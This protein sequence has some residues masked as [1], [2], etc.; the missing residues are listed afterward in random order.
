MNHEPTLSAIRAE[1]AQ[2]HAQLDVDDESITVGAGHPMAQGLIPVEDV[3]ALAETAQL[4][5][6]LY[7][8]EATHREVAANADDA[9][10]EIARLN[11]RIEELERRCAEHAALRHQVISPVGMELVKLAHRWKRSRRGH[12]L[13]GGLYD[14]RER[15][16]HLDLVAELE[17]GGVRIRGLDVSHVGWRSG[18]GSIKVVAAVM[19]NPLVGRILH[20]VAKADDVSLSRLLV[21]VLETAERVE[22]V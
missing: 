4:A 20:E 6:A 2:L 18:E 12:L 13:V 21:Q 10:A 3:C 7:E 14:V 8:A 22:D 11:E 5:Q 16:A 1:L 17:R 19:P 15:V 9:V